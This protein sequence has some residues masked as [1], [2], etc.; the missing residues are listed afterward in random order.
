MNIF[1]SDILP[2]ILL[3]IMI[4]I[5]PAVFIGQKRR[6]PNSIPISVRT[7]AF[8]EATFGILIFFYS[9]YAIVIRKHAPMSWI[10]PSYV[11]L[12]GLALTMLWFILA[13]SL[14]Q[15]VWSARRVCLVMSIFRLPTIIGIIFSAISI[16]LL[17]FT[18]QSHDFYEQSL[19][20]HDLQP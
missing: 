18:R 6:R 20:G 15:G 5:I 2:P 17:Y 7:A 4:F 12:S 11:F 3:F 13:S 19:P 1:F 9:I 16:Y 10:P 8:C 14:S